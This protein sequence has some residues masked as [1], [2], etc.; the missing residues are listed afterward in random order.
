MNYNIESSRWIRW[1]IKLG[2]IDWQPI[3]EE[4]KVKSTEHN[5]ARCIKSCKAPSSSW[6]IPHN[7]YNTSSRELE[8]ADLDSISPKFWFLPHLGCPRASMVWLI[9]HAY[10]FS[11]NKVLQTTI[12]GKLRERERERTKKNTDDECS[13]DKFLSLYKSITEFSNPQVKQNQDG[14]VQE[15]KCKSSCTKYKK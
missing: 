4:N 10:R 2:T 8:S 14:L 11:N 9:S 3:C 6:S 12:I 7:S 13:S 15:V 1:H 5:K